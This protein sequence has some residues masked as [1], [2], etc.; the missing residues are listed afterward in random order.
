MR[1]S[2]LVESLCADN[3]TGL[4][5]KPKLW[6]CALVDTSGRRAFR[7]PLKENIV[8]ESGGIGSENA[9]MSS[10]KEGENPSRRKT[11]GFQGKVC[12]PWVSRDL[13]RG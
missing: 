13:S 10:E 8:R 9:G 2:S 12:L 1:N 5:Y 4:S 3:V 6:I 11:Q 7:R